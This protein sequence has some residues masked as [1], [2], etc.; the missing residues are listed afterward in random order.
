MKNLFIPFHVRA[1]QRNFSFCSVNNLLSSA[2][3]SRSVNVHNVPFLF[4]QSYQF[5]VTSRDW[6]SA[7]VFVC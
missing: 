7:A 3:L 5:N 1:Q 2:E 4:A 6:T